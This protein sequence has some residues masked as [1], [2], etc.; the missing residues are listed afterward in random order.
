MS[1]FLQTLLAILTLTITVVVGVLG[2]VGYQAI[3]RFNS[4][5]DG[6]NIALVTINHPCAPGPC[7]TLAEIDK[8]IVKVG[9][10]IVTTQI[11]E[12]STAPHIV[13]AMDTFKN[14]A[15]HLSTTADSLSTTANALT[16][17]AQSATGTLQA[18][19]ATIAASKPLLIS[20]T[21]TA[22]AS[23]KTIDS[24]N[25]RISDPH[26]DAI[27]GHMD[28]T[29]DSLSGIMADGKKVT[30]KA[31]ADYLAPQP[32]WKKVARYASDTYDYG[33]LFARHTP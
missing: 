9:D 23:T 3:S 4:T 5:V 6:L 24:L 15:A 25:T 29:T 16:Q 21:A 26:I 19:T 17:T 32:W 12:R 27:L 20:L 1:R 18:G 28:S 14:T 10:A 31:T 7:G 8:T 2:F 30:D 33:A 13:T 22:E 11:Q